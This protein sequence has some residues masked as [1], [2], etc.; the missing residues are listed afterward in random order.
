[1]GK[2][3]AE[4]MKDRYHRL[5][6]EGKCPR[7]AAKIKKA[8]RGVHSYCPDCRAYLAERAAERA[9]GNVLRGSRRPAKAVP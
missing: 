8:E 1:M 5:R 7:C 6:A 3:I 2:T 9:K 4:A